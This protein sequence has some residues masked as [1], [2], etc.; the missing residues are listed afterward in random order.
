MIDALIGAGA[1]LLGGLINKGSADE[2]RAA[3]QAMA[4]Q[5]IAAQREFAQNGV[6]WKVDDARA[7][8]VHPL[9]ALGASTHSFSPV[10]VGGGADSSMGDA[11]ASA[12][13]NIGRAVQAGMTRDERTASDALTALQLEKAGLENEMLR[14][15]IGSLKQSQLGPAMPTV[16]QGGPVSTP[17]PVN[18]P[19]K[20]DDLKQK[21]DSVPETEW[22][23]WLGIPLRTNPWFMDAEGAEN[24]Y[25]EAGEQLGGAVNLPADV[26][27]TI[28][29]QYPQWA[30]QLAG[31]LGGRGDHYKSGWG[32]PRRKHW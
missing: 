10:S 26:L 8:G 17:W 6:R 19:V 24:R 1:S 23:R 14:T 9:F 4:Q 3:Q 30:Q 15:Q 7:A 29:K 2:N 20:T 18:A 32:R 11:V 13:Q 31:A 5:N 27:Y 22:T 28:Y 21:P 25:G 12:G 16:S